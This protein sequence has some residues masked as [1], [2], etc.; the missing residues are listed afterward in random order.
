MALAAAQARPL[1]VGVVISRQTFLLILWGAKWPPIREIAVRDDLLD[2]Q[3]S[4]DWVASHLP[5]LQRRID[6]W[7]DANLIV[8]IE[9]VEL[10]GPENAIVGV[11]KEPFP[12]S[13]NVE[14]GAYINA[15]RSGLDILATAL[16][17]RHQVAKARDVQFPVAKSLADYEAGKYKGARFVERL[18]ATERGIIESLRPYRGG[19]DQLW[20]LHHLD[21]LRKHRR[22]LEV[23]INPAVVQ[24]FDEFGQLKIKGVYSGSMGGN[25]KTI[26]A[27]F[28]KGAPKPKIDFTGNVA[29]DEPPIGGRATNLVMLL[30]GFVTLASSIIRLFDK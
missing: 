3:A 18:P 7:L 9:E 10:A 17:I 13:F 28:P 15:I 16:A 24:I 1:D 5:S 23:F 29:I 19:N 8:E 11:E 2:A 4:V 14:V 22:L 25:S 6:S 21:I 20:A 27:Y 26:L 30:D 12:L